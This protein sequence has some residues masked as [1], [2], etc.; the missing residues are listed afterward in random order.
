MQDANFN[1]TAITDTSAVVKERYLFD[2]YGLRTIMNAARSVI[3]DGAGSSDT[4]GSRTTR[5]AGWCT[6]GTGCC[7]L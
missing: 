6:I 5:W 4:K 2:P 1:L 3:S 7:S